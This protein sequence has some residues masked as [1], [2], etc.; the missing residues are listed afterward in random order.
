MNA[1]LLAIGAVA[2]AGVAYFGVKIW[3]GPQVGRGSLDGRVIRPDGVTGAGGAFLKAQSSL[4]AEPIKV[5]VQP[6]GT[7]F[8]ELDVG[9]YTLTAAEGTDAGSL[10][11]EVQLNVHQPGLDIQLTTQA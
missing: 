6:D 1:L 9:D 2:V 11:V 4:R 10:G 3:R 7:Y 5:T 8:A